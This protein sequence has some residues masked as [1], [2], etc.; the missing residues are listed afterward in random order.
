MAAAEAFG[1]DTE[2][3][4]IN[5]TSFQQLRKSFRSTRYQEIQSKFMLNDCLE[6]V[7][8]WDGKLLAAINR[9]EKIDCLAILATFEGK[10]QLL[11]VPKITTSPGEDQAMAV[12]QTVEK[13]GIMNKIQ[14][15][16]CDTTAS[17]TGRINGA[18]T[19][20]ET[21]FGRDLLYLPCRHHILELVLKSCFD[22]LIGPTS[23]YKDIQEI[24][25]RLAET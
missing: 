2:K 8:H 11:R 10:E 12:F 15:L 14:A 21:Y 3:L 22:I 19:N 9:T 1:C 20:L 4:I 24:S 13:W 25:G 7:L 16:C 6:L 23:G 5:R 17:N 18:C